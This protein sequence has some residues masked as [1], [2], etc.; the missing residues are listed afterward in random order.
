M[1]LNDDF[2]QRVLVH[3]DA[4]DWKA[5]PMTYMVDGQQVGVIRNQASRLE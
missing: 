3:A 2:S 5:S 1:G 4:V